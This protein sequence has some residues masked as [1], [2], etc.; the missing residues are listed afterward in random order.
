MRDKQFDNWMKDRLN[1]EIPLSKQNRQAAWEK[2]HL[3]ISQ[4][5]HAAENDFAHIT[6]PLI[7]CEP[8]HMRMWHWVSYFFTQETSYHKAHANS[9]QHYKATPNYRGGLKLHSLELMRHRWTWAL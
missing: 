9:V 6:A 3:S 4:A 2:I 8:L 1:T 7:V 5:T